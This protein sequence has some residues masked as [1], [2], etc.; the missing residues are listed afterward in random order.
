MATH[1][2]KREN[3]YLVCEYCSYATQSKTQMASHNKT[4]RHKRNTE[5]NY[6]VLGI[7]EE[8]IAKAK[9]KADKKKFVKDNADTIILEM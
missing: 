4:D 5:K 3:N 9:A 6:I 1:L 2:L 7:S 8:I